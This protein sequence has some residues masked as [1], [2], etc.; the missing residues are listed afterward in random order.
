ML[1]SF[2]ERADLL[3]IREVAQQTRLPGAD[4]HLGRA[5]A[6]RTALPVFVDDL[7]R[8]KL[9]IGERVVEITA[10]RRKVAALVAYLMTRPGFTAAREQV[11]EAL[12]P[13]SSPA[14]GI[15]SLHQTIYFLRRDL[16]PEYQESVS[17]GY[18]RL[19][20]E[21]VWLDPLLVDSASHRF[22]SIAGST[23][24]DAIVSAIRQYR[25]RFAPEFE[26]EEWAIAT[27]D[28][29]H[30]AYLELVDRALRLLVARAEW[31]EA[32][33]VARLALAVDPA[34][35][36][37]ERGLIAVYE[38]SGAHAAAAEQYAHFAAIQ[39]EEMGVEPPPLSSLVI[40]SD[41][42]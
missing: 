28:S 16:E 21:L 34:A 27:R 22:S 32:A 42:P 17:A 2:G 10:L 23:D 38:Q 11:L 9:V 5:L 29:L 14:V 40:P 31:R 8:T 15:N 25:G 19:E 30:A 39:R 4:R 3:R 41:R 18:V 13:D 33:E 24:R 12:W 7:G 26:Y 35:E 1:D 36:E 20:G 37:I 6:R